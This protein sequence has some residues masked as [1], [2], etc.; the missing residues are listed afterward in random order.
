M[1]VF[2]I[3]A[4][5]L[6]FPRIIIF[7]LWIFSAWFAGV[8]TTWWVPLFGFLC[9]PHTL[10][11]YSAVQNWYNGQWE[12]LQIFVLVLSILADIGVLGIFG[13]KK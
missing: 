13:R 10:L 4:L 2:I 11:W 6:I 8:W 12:F 9:M 5:S 1:G 7:C 3:G